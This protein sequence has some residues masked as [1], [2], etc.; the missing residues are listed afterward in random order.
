[1]KDGS[2]RP[3]VPVPG[4][5]LTRAGTLSTTGHSTNFVMYL[6]VPTDKS[7]SHWINSSVSCSQRHV[8]RELLSE[9]DC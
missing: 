1:M 3:G 8:L 2:T 6:E 5:E 4:A 7:Q 9:E